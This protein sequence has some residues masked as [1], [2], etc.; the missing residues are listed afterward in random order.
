MPLWELVCAMLL[1]LQFFL[2]NSE[3]DVHNLAK[4]KPSI[5]GKGDRVC[6]LLPILGCFP[7]ALEVLLPS[8]GKIII[9]M[10]EEAF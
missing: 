9:Q 4:V 5:C 1:S 2:C 6:V 7:Q 10:W 8:F 3:L